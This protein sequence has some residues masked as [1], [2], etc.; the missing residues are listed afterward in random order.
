MATKIDLGK[1]SVKKIKSYSVKKF[2]LFE[3]R[4]N[5]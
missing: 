1:W 3:A 4:H 2:P 5:Y